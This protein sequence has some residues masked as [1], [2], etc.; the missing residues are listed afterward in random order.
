MHQP[1]SCAQNDCHSSAEIMKTLMIRVLEN[2]WMNSYVICRYCRQ[3]IVYQGLGMIVTVLSSKLKWR[4]RYNSSSCFTSAVL[5]DMAS[6]W[7]TVEDQTIEEVTE[8]MISNKMVCQMQEW[9]SLVLLSRINLLMAPKWP[10]LFTSITLLQI[11]HV[12]SNFAFTTASASTSS[13]DSPLWLL[14]NVV[15]WVHCQCNHAVYYLH[16]LLFCEMAG[17]WPQFIT[18]RVQSLYVGAEQG[19]LSASCWPYKPHCLSL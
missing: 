16:N 4:F 1:S 8:D 5:L 11:I 18:A 6:S 14:A 3:S 7:Q 12:A 17:V 15:F 9:W 19:D 2:K 13:C 10:S